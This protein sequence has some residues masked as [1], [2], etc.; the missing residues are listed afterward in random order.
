[1]RFRNSW[2]DATVTDVKK[3]AD[4]IFQI[5]IQALDGTHPFTVGSH[6]DVAVMIN[7]QPEVRSYSLVGKFAPDQPYTIAVKHLVNSRGGSNH[8]CALQK[9]NRIKVSS[10]LNHFE[11]SFNSNQYL[12]IAGGI[13]ITPVIGMAQELKEKGSDVFMIYI[14]KSESD[15]A[16]V[17]KLRNLLGDNLIVHFSDQKGHYQLENIL[18]FVSSTSFVYLCGPLGLMNAVR[19]IWE[20]SDYNNANLRFETFG[21]SGLFSPQKFTVK[22]PRFEKEIEVSEN[23]SLL[24]ALNAANVDVMFDCNKGECGLCQV[25]VVEYTGSIDHR[26]CFFSEE[27]KG[28][29]KKICA[30][31]SRVANGHLTIDTAYRGKNFSSSK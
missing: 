9:G 20:E 15:M 31:V 12:L 3:I 17:E 11:L 14:G 18:D 26:D 1:M 10:P 22:I 24:Q 8:M 13:G 7:G 28:E 27:E 5:K 2:M 4:R 29:N 30:C 23:Q 21:A 19:K 6:I 16:Y 25:D